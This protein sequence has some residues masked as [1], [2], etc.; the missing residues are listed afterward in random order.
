MKTN[1]KTWILIAFII[2]IAI[3]GCKTESVLDDPF[4]NQELCIDEVYGKSV[5]LEDAPDKTKKLWQEYQRRI[6]N[7]ESS[8][9]PYMKQLAYVLRFTKTAKQEEKLFNIPAE[10]SL[11]QGILESGNG[12][13]ELSRVYNNHFGIKC[14]KKEC[15]DEFKMWRTLQAKI[16]SYQCSKDSHKCGKGSRFVN[17]CCV[18]FAD[19]DKADRF[20]VYHSAWES[21][22]DHSKHLTKQRY[23]P[24]QD[25]KT[26]QKWAECLKEK[27]YATSQTYSEKL[28]YLIEI[29]NL[30]EL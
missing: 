3:F 1:N 18:N 9:S 14:T 21:W 8:D 27:G 29:H 25:C 17:G 28:I 11:A 7:G 30:N 6:E 4:C 20:K 10:I 12:Q 23:K 19:D 2:A 22:R 5:S 26:Y 15:R 24:C 13:S 16:C